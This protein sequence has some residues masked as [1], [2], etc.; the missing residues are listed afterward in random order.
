MTK[1]MTQPM[2]KH[3]FSVHKLIRDKLPHMIRSAGIVVSDYVMDD[4]EYSEKLNQKLLEEAQEVLAAVKPK[5]ILEE[6][7]DV[8]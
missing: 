1:P 3:R 5:E 8:L 6:L 4:A 2:I 7:A